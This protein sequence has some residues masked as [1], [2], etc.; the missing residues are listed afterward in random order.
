MFVIASGVI[1]GL[2][3]AMVLTRFISSQIWE[4]RTMDL[5]TFAGVTLVLMA[6]ALLACLIPTRRAVKVDPTTA[7][8][9]E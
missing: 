9:S 6:I 4:V 3:G 5:G 8:R 2:G 7:L 1:L